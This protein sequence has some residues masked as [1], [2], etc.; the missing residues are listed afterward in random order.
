MSVLSGLSKMARGRE[1]SARH[2][3]IVP[4]ADRII[5]RMV[6]VEALRGEMPTGTSRSCY[7]IMRV[8]GV[9]HFCRLLVALGKE[10]FHQGYEFACELT[11]RETL[12]FLLRHCYP[13]AGDTPQTLRS[14]ARGA[15]TIWKN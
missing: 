15:N 9:E 14:L 7:G 11:K 4:L 12:S 13:A 1:L 3:W 2:P 8:E 5:H 10:R 6:D